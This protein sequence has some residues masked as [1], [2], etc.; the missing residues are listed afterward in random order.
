MPLYK[1]LS[2]FDHPDWIMMKNSPENIRE[3]P[4]TAWL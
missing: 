2:A 1:L 3:K 4:G